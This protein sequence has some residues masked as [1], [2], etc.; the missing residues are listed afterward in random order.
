MIGSGCDKLI[1]AAYKIGLL[2]FECRKKCTYHLE[3]FVQYQL[4]VQV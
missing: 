1:T 3:L 4:K 2:N